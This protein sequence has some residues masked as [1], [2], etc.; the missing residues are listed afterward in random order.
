MPIDHQ[1]AINETRAAEPGRML[2][3]GAWREAGSHLPVIDPSTALEFGRI[4]QSSPKDVDDAVAAARAAFNGPWRNLN[5]GKRKALLLKLAELTEAH[6]KELNALLS[7]EMGAS[8]QITGLLGALSLQRNLEYFAS[9]IDKIYGEVIPV[10][11]AFDYAVREPLGVVGVI[12][13]WNT[14]LLFVG[15]KLGPALATGNTVVLK[16]GE[17]ASL[18]VLRWAQLIKEAGIPDGVINIIPG[19]GQVGAM[20]AAHSGVDKISFTGS[21]ETGR[22]VA[23]LAANNLTKVSMELGG[24]SASLI[25]KDASLT[26]ATMMSAFGIFGLS[27]QIC[28]GCSRL[29]IEEPIYAEMVENLSSF[30]S[31]LPLGDPM[32]RSTVIG[33]LVAQRQL[34]RV[35]GYVEAGKKEAKLKRG[36]NRA[37]GDLANGYFVEPTIFT[38]VPLSAKIAQEEIFGP[39]LCLAPFKTLEEAIALA[40]GTKYG[41]AAGIWSESINTVH[42][43]AAA[44]DAGVIWVNGYGSLPASVP[45]GGTKQSGYGRDGGRDVLLEYTQAKNVLI[46]IM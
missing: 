32:E 25:F 10:G 45:F 20:L 17:L 12:I 16:P 2:I 23:A 29:Y 7:I 21:V 41:L 40:N 8:S 19:D 4:G 11:G 27:G 31:G 28:A 34:E 24:K 1:K 6:R 43:A 9:W 18:A 3:N 30:A 22:K 15:S 44:L 33:P 35:M 42:K 39:V 38:D 37:S 5:P 14:P 36:G 46:E 26:K 13:P